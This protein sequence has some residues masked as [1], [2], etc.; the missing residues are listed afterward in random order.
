MSMTD[1]IADMLTRIRNACG[2]KH[3][4]VD[5]PVSKMKTEIARILKENN[6]IQDYSTLETDEGQA[7]AARASQVR[8]RPAGDSRAAARVDA[9]PAQVRRRRRDPARAQRTRHRDSQHEQGP[10]VRP[11]GAAVAHR[12]RARRRRLVTET[13]SMSRIGKLP[14]PIPNGVTVTVDGNTVKVKGPKGELSHELPDGDHA[15][16]AKATTLTVKRAVGRD[17]P[18]VAARSHALADREHGGGRDEGLLEAARDHGRRLQG[19]GAAVRAAARARLLALDRVQGARRA[20]SSPRR[21]RRRS[22]STGA[23]K[24]LVGQVAAEIRSLRPPEPYKGKG[25]RYAGEVIR[26]KAGKAGGK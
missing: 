15:S 26:R 19:R 16:I 8:R 22:S 24:A 20:S 7:A 17:E 11:R 21:S 12:R 25:I 1:P 14:V 18:Q 13:T 10:D 2:S 23:D 9:R 5:M 3:R 4:R 6:Y